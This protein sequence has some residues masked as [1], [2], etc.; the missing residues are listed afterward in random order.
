MSF[1]NADDLKSRVLSQDLLIYITHLEKAFSEIEES[2]EK[3]IIQVPKQRITGAMALKLSEARC[4]HWTC[5][6][7]VCLIYSVKHVL[8]HNIILFINISIQTV[9]DL[10][11]FLQ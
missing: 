10:S 1:V 3:N 5:M 8:V 11:R 6:L 7:S 2:D 9:T 4:M